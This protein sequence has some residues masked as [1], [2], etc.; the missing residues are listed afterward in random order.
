[1]GRLGHTGNSEPM[2]TA[3]WADPRIRRFE[4]GTTVLALHLRWIREA[5]VR[6]M[7]RVPKALEAVDVAEILCTVVMAKDGRR[8]RISCT[9][10]CPI[11]LFG[12]VLGDG[13]FVVPRPLK[14]LMIFL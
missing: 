4:T 10:E 5:N 9:R 6:A 13:S 1:M 12:D 11:H 3:K 7:D 2:L 8:V 14:S